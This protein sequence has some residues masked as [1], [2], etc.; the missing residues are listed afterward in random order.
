MFISQ[1]LRL[2]CTGVHSQLDPQASEAEWGS[3]L[4]KLEMS[5]EHPMK[6]LQ[7]TPAFSR[8]LHGFAS[9]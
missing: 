4:S 2:L 1:A 8:Q 7:E 6:M 9:I 5:H 3:S